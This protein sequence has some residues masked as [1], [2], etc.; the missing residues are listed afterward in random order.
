VNLIAVSSND[1]ATVV[2]DGPAKVQAA[3]ALAL[4]DEVASDANGRAV[5][6]STGNVIGGLVT[7]RGIAPSGGKYDRAEIQTQAIKP[8]AA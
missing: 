3:V 7:E 4:G 6:A 8:T 5:V 1:T 2:V